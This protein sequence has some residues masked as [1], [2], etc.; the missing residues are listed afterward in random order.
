MTQVSNIS[1]RIDLKGKAAVVTGASRG[2][3]K[4]AC[5]ALAKEGA[6]IGALDLLEAEDVCRE[7]KDQGRKALKAV[8][9]ISDPGQIRSAVSFMAEEL[10]RIDILVNNAGVLGDSSKSLGDYNPDDWDKILTTNVR[11]PALVT[12]EVWPHMVRQGGGKIV[13]I[14]S[15]AGR[16]G[17][18]RAGGHYAASKGA[19]HSFVKWAASKGASKGIYVNGIA[20][21]PI[22]TPMIVSEGYTSEGIPLGRLGQPIDVAMAVVFLASQAS[23]YITG[24]VL[25]VNG[26]VLMV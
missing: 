1:S 25:D 6:D 18:L 20:P 5:L 4:A 12:Q 8:C 11:G 14:G 10:G 2:I 19:I 13:F 22:E 26:G 3:G 15:I 21:G 23:N 9:D 24:Q 7:V 17:G 16:I